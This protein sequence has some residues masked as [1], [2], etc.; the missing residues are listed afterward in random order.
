[1]AADGRETRGW[2]ITSSDC[3]K[4]RRGFDACRNKVIYGI[5]GEGSV[6]DAAVDWATAGANPE[7]VPK[8]EEGWSLIVISA[9]SVIS[10]DSKSPYPSRHKLPC[11]FGNGRDFARAAMLCGKTPTEAIEIAIQCDA[12]SGGTILTLDIVEAAPLQVAAE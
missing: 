4:I 9:T 5:T 1:M 6:F 3:V 10:Y 12:S 7:K 11:A 8:T 2:E